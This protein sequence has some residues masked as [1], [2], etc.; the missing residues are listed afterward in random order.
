MNIPKLTQIAFFSIAIL[1][2]YLILTTSIKSDGDGI[3]TTIFGL[4][5]MYHLV[6]LAVQLIRKKYQSAKTS[7]ISVLL[8]VLLLLKLGYVYYN[9]YVSSTILLLIIIWAFRTHNNVKAFIKEQKLITT[10]LLLN[11]GLL[12]ISDTS[13]LIYINH[14]TIAWKPDLSWSDFRD[15][16]PK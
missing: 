7:N 2:G 9:F 4:F 16:H 3:L 6:K 5:I 8:F 14:N 15:D 10:L 13:I 1:G 12:F 11:I